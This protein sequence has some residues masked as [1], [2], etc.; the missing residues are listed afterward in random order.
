VNSSELYLTS[1]NYFS[2]IRGKS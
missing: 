2:I 1:G